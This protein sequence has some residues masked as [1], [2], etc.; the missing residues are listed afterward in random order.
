MVFDTLMN[1]DYSYVFSVGIKFATDKSGFEKFMYDNWR[2]GREDYVR[3]VVATAFTLECVEGEE[4]L[5]DI[6]TLDF[7]YGESE[8]GQKQLLHDVCEYF[9]DSK[10][11]IVNKYRQ[12]L[13]DY[14]E[15]I[16]LRNQYQHLNYLKFEPLIK[17]TN[18]LKLMSYNRKKVIISTV[19]E[20]GKKASTGVYRI[21]MAGATPSKFSVWRG[22]EKTS[23]WGTEEGIT[24]IIAADSYEMLFQ[25]QYVEND[26]LSEYQKTAFVYG[27]E[28]ANEVYHNRVKE[29]TTR[30]NRKTPVTRNIDEVCAE[31]GL[32]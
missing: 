22:A 28:K 32:F 17:S 20:H 25:N 27:I 9:G 7:V 14:D 30:N 24:S 18:Y 21:R 6:H 31:N 29:L 26:K 11:E 23:L 15:I 13:V 8:D 3:A 2:L 12:C 5:H 10:S 19:T 16:T 4:K 1:K